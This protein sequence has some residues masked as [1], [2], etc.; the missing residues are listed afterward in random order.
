MTGNDIIEINQ[1]SNLFL[2]VKDFIIQGIFKD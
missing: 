1:E 2:P